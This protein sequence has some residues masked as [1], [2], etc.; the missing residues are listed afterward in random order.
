VFWHNQAVMHRH[1]LRAVFVPISGAAAAYRPPQG[2][3]AWKCLICNA[4][5]RLPTAQALLYYYHYL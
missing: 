5:N 3:T 2:L 1:G 4:K